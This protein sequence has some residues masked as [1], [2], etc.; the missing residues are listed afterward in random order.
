MQA[1]ELKKTHPGKYIGILAYSWH[2][3]PPG[4]DLEDNIFVQL[5]AGMNSSRFSFEDLLTG[6]SERSSKM[7]IYEYYSYWE[8][9]KCMLPG[10]GILL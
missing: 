2:S 8:M 7:G 9:D 6:W 4:F 10:G 5:T 1:K 3:D